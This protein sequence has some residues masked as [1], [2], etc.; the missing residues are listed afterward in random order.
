MNLIT[1]VGGNLTQW[2]LTRGPR[3]EIWLTTK[4]LNWANIGVY[5]ANSIIRVWDAN[6]VIRCRFKLPQLNW[7][8]RDALESHRPPWSTPVVENKREKGSNRTSLHVSAGLVTSLA[9]L[10]VTRLILCSYAG[11][12]LIECDGHWR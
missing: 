4:W 3:I 10:G 11:P 6:Y 7:T 2:D 8:R 5:G 9:L 1:E 12:Q